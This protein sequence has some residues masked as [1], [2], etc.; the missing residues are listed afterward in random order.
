MFIKMKACSSHSIPTDTTNSEMVHCKDVRS[1]DT[2]FDFIWS[3]ISIKW[4]RKVEGYRRWSEL[5]RAIKKNEAF[6]VSKTKSWTNCPS[7]DQDL[8]TYT[9]ALYTLD[10]NVMSSRGQSLR[11]RSHGAT[12][13]GTEP[14]VSSLTSTLN[15]L[16]SCSDIIQTHCF[17]W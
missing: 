14:H 8:Q 2:W 4:W 13:F 9:D 10:W 11:G 3:V 12:S 15:S 5:V 7:S 17:G 1:G 6:S 16:H